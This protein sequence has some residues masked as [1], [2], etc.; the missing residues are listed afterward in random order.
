MK[1]V[2]IIGAGFSGLATAASLAKKGFKVKVLEKHK[3]A[4]GR[5]RKFETE[6][7]TFDMGPSW[8]WMPDVFDNYFASF[9]KKTSDYY[10][11]MRLDPSY[12][13]FW[14]REEITDIPASEKDLF[15]LF[16]SLESGAGEKLR[17][18]LKDAKFK[19][20]IGMNDLVHKP[21]YSA[22][23]FAEFSILANAMKLQIFRSFEKHIKKYF[24]DPKI[25][26][27]LEFPILFLGGTAK[28]TPALYSLMNYADMRL[29]TWYPMGGMHKVVAGMQKLAEELGAEFVFD[30]NVERIVV[31]NRKVSRVE[32]QDGI[33]DADYIVS[34]ADYNHTEQALLGKDYQNY[35]EKYWD[36]KVMSPSSLIFYL[37]INKKV[38]GISHHT[39][40][41][42]EDFSAHA[43]DIYKDPRWP[44]KPSFY[45]SC[46]SKTD[47][48]VAPEGYE[49]MFM[50]MPVAS[51]LED[52]EETRE[53][54]FEM[55][56][57]RFEKLS[58]ESIRN[59]IVFKRS[60]AH[61]DFVK[62]YNAFKGNA[63]GL[64]NTLMQTAFMKPGLKNKKVS[65]LFYTGQLTVPGPG[66]PPAL[67]S[68][69]IVAG[70]IAKLAGVE[71]E[72]KEMVSI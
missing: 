11:L 53:K 24:K 68:G 49:N 58:G 29:G 59:N 33:Y 28:N 19:Y 31:E 67:I 38:K 2:I 71:K 30:Q 66:V 40:F 10:D 63:Y 4:G 18:F 64:A 54:Y 20:D 17:A 14:S 52:N 5:A 50:L 56:L 70:E 36:S 72:V 32:T 44:E 3:M 51:G 21:S 62:D 1:N 47:T 23:E 25:L 9:G 26:Q 55:F 57:D 37:G 15:S 16:E 39:L 35:S 61:R 43:D 45:I 48:T 8:Y 34:S 42:D 13:V 46:P 22:L 6:G 69:Q 27:L 12:K 65:N 41:F 60:Y 7:F